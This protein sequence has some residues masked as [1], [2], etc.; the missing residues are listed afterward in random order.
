MFIGRSIQWL[1][2]SRRSKRFSDQAFPADGEPLA[3]PRLAR[4]LEEAQITGQLEHPGIVPVH[5]IGV[6]AQGHAYFTMSLVEGRNLSVALSASDSDGP[7]PLVF[8]ESNNLPNG[9][10]ILTDNGN[11]SGT[12][13]LNPN[14]PSAG[15]YNI[16]VTASD[17]N[18]TDVESFTLT[19]LDINQQPAV[20]PV[21][22]HG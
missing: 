20:V 12:F 19:V 8:G 10:G 13:T 4:F 5:E 2:P 3:P 16:S 18:L 6:T 7:A 21:G 15:T 11:G 22:D 9:G 1:A 14:F 17:S